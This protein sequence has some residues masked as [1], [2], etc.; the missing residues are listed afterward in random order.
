MPSD[1]SSF[2]IVRQPSLAVAPLVTF[3]QITGHFTQAVSCTIY[4]WAYLTSQKLLSYLP[5]FNPC[6]EPA[7]E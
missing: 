4:L 6:L 5:I 2:F 7:P 3:L 1:F